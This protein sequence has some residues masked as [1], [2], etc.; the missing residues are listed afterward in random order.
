MSR[1]AIGQCRR[2]EPVRRCAASR[3]GLRFPHGCGSG[4]GVPGRWFRRVPASRSTVRQGAGG[5]QRTGVARRHGNGG[6]ARADG[7]RSHARRLDARCWSVPVPSIHCASHD[8]CLA[9][10]APSE[11]YCAGPIVRRR[12]LRSAAARSTAVAALR[13]HCAVRVGQRLRGHLPT[14][15]ASQ[16]GSSSGGVLRALHSR[17]AGHAVLRTAPPARTGRAHAGR[18]RAERMRAVIRATVAGSWSLPPPACWRSATASFTPRQRNGLRA[19]TRE[20]GAP[21]RLPS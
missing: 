15:H 2:S 5:R 8:G 13:L 12:R 18:A 6:A 10:R 17:A 14:S 21:G 3:P 7:L 19:C 11:L 1:M 16:L 9:A 4:Q 20:T